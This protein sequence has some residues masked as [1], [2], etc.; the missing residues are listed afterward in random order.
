MS[1][2]KILIREDRSLFNPAPLKHGPVYI[3]FRV[4]KYTDKSCTFSPDLCIKV[5]GMLG[6]FGVPG[7]ISEGV[8]PGVI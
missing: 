2:R 8:V 5:S 3:C 1:E 6:G 7:V 4:Q